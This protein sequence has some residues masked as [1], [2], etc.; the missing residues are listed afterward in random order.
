M[1]QKNEIILSGEYVALLGDIKK[2]IIS[3]RIKTA[4]SVNKALIQLY[5]EIGKSITEKQAQN[6]WGD[7]IVENLSID[8]RKEFQNTFGLS[9]QNLW[10]M[11]KFYVEYK[12]KP[13]LQQL[14]GE[15]PWGHNILILSIKDAKEKEYYLRSSTEMG[16]ARNVLLN[17][18]KADAYQLSLKKKKHNFEK[19]LPMHLAE[20][21]NESLKSVYN[22]D[23]LGI[24]MPV[25]ER[26]LEK[27]IVEKIKHFIL[28]LGAGFSFIGNQYR[29]VLEDE[30][31]FIDLL[32][33]N[34]KL[35][36]LVAVELKTGDFKPEYV[37]KMDFYLHLLNDKIRLKDENPSIGIILCAQKKNI[38][39]EYALRSTK[40]PV[41]VAEYKLTK[42]LPANLKKYLPSE[43]DLI[44]QIKEEIG[45]R[46]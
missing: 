22:L 35:K 36:C 21:A 13:I 24:T 33:F 6:G 2:R 25:L 16:W 46:K 26:E 28:E 14:V 41:G 4:R 8:L 45:E 32:F 7:G 15:L 5:W 40:N 44:A 20:Q 37:G 19:A 34:R 3:A 42:K 10:Y 29:L 31:Y 9:V 39:V 38:V 30:E 18:I 27:R 43:K 11:R 1:R 17:Q 12:D 23:F